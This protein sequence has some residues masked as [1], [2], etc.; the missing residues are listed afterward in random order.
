MGHWHEGRFHH[1]HPG[2]LYQVSPSDKALKPLSTGYQLGNLD[3]VVRHKDTLYIS[4]WISGELYQLRDNQR[5]IVLSTNPGLADIGADA[6]TL[7][8]PMM[9]DNTLVAW[10]LP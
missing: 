7:Y 5:R 2:S 9:M 1:R 8:A 6:G 3:G 10:Q 4:D